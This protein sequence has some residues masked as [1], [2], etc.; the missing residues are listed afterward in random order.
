MALRAGSR[1]RPGAGGACHSLSCHP[2]PLDR[3]TL[4]ATPPP[5]LTALGASLEGP[6]WGRPPQRTQ[7]SINGHCHEAGKI[8]TNRQDPEPPR[9]QGAS[10]PSYLLKAVSAPPSAWLPLTSPAQLPVYVPQVALPP[11]A[12]QSSLR[13]CGC[14]LS[15]VPTS[16]GHAPPT[17]RLWEAVTSTRKS[18]VL[19]AHLDG[20]VSGVGRRRG[21]GEKVQPVALSP[22]PP[23]SS[24]S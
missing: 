1:E 13:V 4:S 8:S 6:G 22:P 24:L 5:G 16:L 17:Q 11:N 2:H 15:G 14:C 21:S 7:T 9:A 3:R 18:K 10:G 23:N 19:G 12:P 20:P